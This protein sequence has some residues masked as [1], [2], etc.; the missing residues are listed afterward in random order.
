V[1]LDIARFKGVEYLKPGEPIT[2]ADFKA[3]A[4]KQGV[5]FQTGDIVIFRTGWIPALGKYPELKKAP[6]FNE[7][8]IQ[9]SLEFLKWFQDTGVSMI[10]ADSIAME[11]THSPP[12][13]KGSMIPFIN[14]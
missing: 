9:Y 11:Q 12:K 4:K 7:P 14:I 2:L 6:V 13:E 3:C 1:L 5:N 8:G 10:A